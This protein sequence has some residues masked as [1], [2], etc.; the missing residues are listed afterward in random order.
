MWSLAIYD[1]DNK[2][3]VKL[4]RISCAEKFVLIERGVKDLALISMQDGKQIGIYTTLEKLKD[5]SKII[6]I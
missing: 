2:K 6:E 4:K 3:N 5:A 1:F